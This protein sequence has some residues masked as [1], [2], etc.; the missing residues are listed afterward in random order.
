MDWIHWWLLCTSI[1]TFGNH[2]RLVWRLASHDALPSAE[3]PPSTCQ[4]HYHY[5]RFS[6]SEEVLKAVGSIFAFLYCCQSLMDASGVH[7][8]KQASCSSLP[9][10]GETTYNVT[11]R[12]VRVITV[13][14]EEQYYYLFWVCVCLPQCA[15][16]MLSSVAC[17]SVQY[18]STLYHKRHDF[19][20]KKKSE[21][22][23]CVVI[24]CTILYETFLILR[25]TGR[26]IIKNIYWSSCKVPVILARF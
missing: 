8:D 23:M 7:N 26:D 17:Q 3:L 21:H 6:Y 13:A 1:W 25:R 15:C 12:R 19:R 20:G 10:I 4:Q 14:V 11:L 5:T 9:S 18:F 2:R 16:A 24:F 22:K